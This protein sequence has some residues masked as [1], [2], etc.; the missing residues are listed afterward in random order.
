MSRYSVLQQTSTNNRVCFKQ[1][2]TIPPPLSISK[3]LPTCLKISRDIKEDLLQ[4]EILPTA[5]LFIA[6]AVAMYTN[7]K[8]SR[9]TLRGIGMFLHQ[10]RHWNPVPCSILSEALCLLMHHNVFQFGDMYFKKLKG[11]AMGTA[12]GCSYANLF[13][14]IYENCIYINTTIFSTSKD[15]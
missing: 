15:M 11:T 1:E 2:P 10:H 4:L 5:K 8:T 7:I 12:V 14:S 9:P 13:F 6:D 3:K